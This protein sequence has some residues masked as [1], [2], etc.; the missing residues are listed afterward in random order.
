[1]TRAEDSPE[2]ARETAGCVRWRRADAID[3]SPAP[4]LGEE[5]RPPASSL[6]VNGRSRCAH[7]AGT[8]PNSRWLAWS[9]PALGRRGIGRPIA[10]SCRPIG[11]PAAILLSPARVWAAAADASPSRSSGSPLADESRRLVGVL[12]RRR[13]HLQP[14]TK[15][16]ASREWQPLFIEIVRGLLARPYEKKITGHYDARCSA[17]LQDYCAAHR[18]RRRRAAL[19]RRAFW[20]CF[21]TTRAPLLLRQVPKPI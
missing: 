14:A 13:Q 10:R 11:R 16:I 21:D 5:A 9:R 8:S 7:S 20:G 4:Q 15:F 1:M 6:T 17:T 18:C 19:R 2:V 3:N 12:S